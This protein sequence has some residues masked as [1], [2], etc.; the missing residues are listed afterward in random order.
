MKKHLSKYNKLVRED[1]MI[2]GLSKMKRD[3]IEKEFKARFKLYIGN[4]SGRKGYIPKEKSGFSPD[5]D[6]KEFF[7]MYE[8]TF[9][10]KSKP[11]DK[12]PQVKKDKKK[13]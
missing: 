6:T 5:Y 3:E 7:K 9:N 2:K 12:K 4:I 8:D 13:K 10:K 11:S 1:L